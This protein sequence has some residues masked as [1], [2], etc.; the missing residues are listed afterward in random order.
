MEVV[1]IVT[2]SRNPSPE[3]EAEAARWAANLGA[4]L[5]RRGDLSLADLTRETGAAGALVI[6]GDRVTY[7]EPERDLS[8]FFHP[9]MARQRIRNLQAGRGDPMVTAM[10]LRPGDRVL[11][12]TLGRATDATVASYAVGP[13]GKVVGVEKSPVLAWM[14]IEGLA[15]Y[16]MADR[17]TQAAM[18][19]IEAHCA[20][21]HEFLDA[22][23]PGSFD[24]VYFDPLFDAP[25]PGAC[26]MLPLRA[27]ASPEPLT[28]EGVTAAL[29]VARRCVVVKQPTGSPFWERLPFTFAFVSGGKS[30]V[31]YGV[32]EAAASTQ[33]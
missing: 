26:A 9:G 17:D 16:E 13:E 8:Y 25:L 6:G 1:L 7:W 23:D 5:V 21:H 30:R 2:T 14:T 28:T 10:R 18:R 19:R 20:D 29:R 22:Q 4:P 12:C 32:V 15:H 33:P 3:R 24:V 27:L 31:E 11:D